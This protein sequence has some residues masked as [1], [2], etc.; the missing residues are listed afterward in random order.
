M[1]KESCR[2]EGFPLMCYFIPVRDGAGVWTFGNLRLPPLQQ[3]RPK[4]IKLHKI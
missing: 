3:E 4:H 2:S 1:Y